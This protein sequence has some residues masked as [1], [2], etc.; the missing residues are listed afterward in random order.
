[1]EQSVNFVTNKN[2]TTI[3]IQNLHISFTDLCSDE[4]DEDIEV[5]IESDD[6]LERKK[7]REANK[8]RNREKAL[9]MLMPQQC[10]EAT[11]LNV[12]RD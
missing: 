3:F 12:R 6:V 2:E 10:D 9:K 7:Y 5:K 1:M 11:E 4:D 8:Q